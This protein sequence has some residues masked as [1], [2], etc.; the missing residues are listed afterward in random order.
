[1]SSTALIR[2]SLYPILLLKCQCI[3]SFVNQVHQFLRRENAIVKGP[4]E[5]DCRVLYVSD[6]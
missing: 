6:D 1:M 3:L 4:L 5:G 2:M